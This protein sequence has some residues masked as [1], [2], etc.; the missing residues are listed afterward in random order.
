[1]LDDGEMIEIILDDYFL[2]Y[3]YNNMAV[4][5]K[6]VKEELWAMV[7]E[8]AYAKRFGSYA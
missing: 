4:F 1:M 3:N 8:K 6:G 5:A 2:I 7:L